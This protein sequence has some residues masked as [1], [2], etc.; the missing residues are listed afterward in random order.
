MFVQLRFWVTQKV[1]SFFLKV[2]L[3]TTCLTF[4][5][6]NCIIN[7]IVIF[8]E[9]DISDT[10]TEL[11]ENTRNNDWRV[12]GALGLMLASGICNGIAVLTLL[13]Y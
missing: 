13:A 11:R 4:H 9:G 2:N 5:K 1:D 10:T 6:L 12:A 8:K 7:N 3:S